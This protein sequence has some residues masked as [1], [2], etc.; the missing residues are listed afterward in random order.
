[1]SEEIPGYDA[2]KLRTPEE[3]MPWLAEEEPE[4]EPEI[5]DEDY[6]P[7]PWCNGCGAMRKADCHCGPIA[8]NE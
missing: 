8:D 7:T 1:M 3:D 5:E 6:D 2:W 4:D